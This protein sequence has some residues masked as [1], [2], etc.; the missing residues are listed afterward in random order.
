M[1]LTNVDEIL[2]ESSDDDNLKVG[3]V[4]DNSDSTGCGRVKAN[5]PELF[6]SEAGPIPWIGSNLNSPFGAGHNYGWY[7]TP[8]EGSK[9][10]VHFQAQDKN[11][12]LKVADHVT[13]EDVPTK[14]R[15]PNTWGFRDPTGN[16]LY[17]NLDTNEYTFTSAQGVQ[18][19]ITGTTVLFNAPGDLQIQS[20]T[21]VIVKAPKIDL[22]N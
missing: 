10:R 15:N 22:T 17:V 4:V 6:N 9:I 8:Y 7:G 18:L 20:G 13:P 3:T 1:S 19:K 11:F 16:E 14:F 2:N 12:G 21:H 5:I